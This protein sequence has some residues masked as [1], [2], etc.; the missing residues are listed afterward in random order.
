ML[1]L[2]S[3]NQF[4]L[5]NVSYN[6]KVVNFFLTLFKTISTLQSRKLFVF[7]HWLFTTFKFLIRNTLDTYNLYNNGNQMN[8]VLLYAN[9]MLHLGQREKTNNGEIYVLNF[10][11]VTK[12]FTTNAYGYEF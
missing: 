5:L 8:L 10:N 1:N 3:Q 12:R 11:H 7:V 6:I 4:L 9:N 2:R